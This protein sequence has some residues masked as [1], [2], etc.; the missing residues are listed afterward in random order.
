MNLHFINC[1][2]CQKPVTENETQI[3]C[4]NDKRYHYHYSKIHN[5]ANI[6]IAK[7][8]NLVYNQPDKIST[9][10]VV[11]KINGYGWEEIFSVNFHI[12]LDF[13]N[14]ERAVQRIRGLIIFS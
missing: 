12:E 8:I 14:L 13:N 1:P 7:D 10:V 9:K 5:V 2:I 11:P 6:H 3:F 4:L